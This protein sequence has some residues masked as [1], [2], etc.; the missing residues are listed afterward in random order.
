VDLS[1]LKILL[2]DDEEAVRDVAELM[3]GMLGVEVDG[4]ADGQEAMTRFS[5][6]PDRYHLVLLD[7]TMPEMD[8]EV[9]F[10]ELRRVRSDIRVVLSSGYNEQELAE[11]FA[12]TGFSG[13]IQKPYSIDRLRQTLVAA[14]DGA[15]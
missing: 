8:G 15:R 9:C 11:R 12:S 13:F 2:V 6:H 10:H 4:A 14:L 5:E 1:G 7:L 3:L